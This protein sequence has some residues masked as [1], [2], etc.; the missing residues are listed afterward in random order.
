M[1]RLAIFNKLRVMQPSSQWDFRTLMFPPD[2]PLARLHLIPSHP[3]RQETTSL[4]SASL[5][6]PFLIFYGNGIIQEVVLWIWVPL[7]DIMSV[8]ASRVVRV[9]SFLLRSGIPLCGYPTSVFISGEAFGLF[10]I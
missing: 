9:Y 6:G 5:I 1:C 8:R 4:L 10:P 3:E 7:P 2:L